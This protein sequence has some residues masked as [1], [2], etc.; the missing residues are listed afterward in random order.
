M[1]YFVSKVSQEFLRK[2]KKCTFPPPYKFPG[3]RD[4]VRNHINGHKTTLSFRIFFNKHC[5][6]SSCACLCVWM[7]VHV[8]ASTQETQKSALSSSN[9]PAYPPHPALLPLPLYLLTP[10]CLDITLV[11][12]LQ[13]QVRRGEEERDADLM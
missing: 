2:C 5:L 10:F 9:S 11:Q 6:A 8:C 4:D 3:A 13:S 12:V 7:Y 1:V